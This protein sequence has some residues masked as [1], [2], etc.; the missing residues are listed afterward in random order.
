M[1]KNAD[2]AAGV[3]DRIRSEGGQA[4]AMRAD[5]GV[6]ADILAL[7]E[8][9]DQLG[10]LQALVYNSGITGPASSLV[11]ADT[12]V[13]ARVLEV[14]LL[15][16]MVASR[17]AIRRMSKSR[18]GQGGSIVLISSRAALYGSP[19]EFVWYAASKGGMGQ[20]DQRPGARSRAR[21]HPRQRRLAG[22]IVTEMHRPGKLDSAIKL[23]PPCSARARP[24]KWPRR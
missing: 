22:P 8:R 14:N 21:G 18:G 15:G 5:T 19:G 24:R 17:E 9:A 11:E 1:W 13:M 20:P 6:E 3:V 7:F 23:S 2:R 10:R 12:S 16:A 4:E